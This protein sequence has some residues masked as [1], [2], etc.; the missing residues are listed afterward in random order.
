M[1]NRDR[2]RDQGSPDLPPDTPA[3]GHEDGD[4]TDSRRIRE[5][6]D[7]DNERQ[8]PRRDPAPGGS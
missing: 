4:G 3:P 8:P 6:N 1:N 7:R 5:E 2:V